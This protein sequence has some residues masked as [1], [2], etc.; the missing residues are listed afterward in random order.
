MKYY[1]YFLIL[2]YLSY[3][4]NMCIINHFNYYLLFFISYLYSNY[5]GQYHLDV[6]CYKVIQEQNFVLQTLLIF[7]HYF[8]ITVI[9]F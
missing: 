3:L 9:Y 8:K 1:K 2:I 5:I 7:N 6:H 4:L